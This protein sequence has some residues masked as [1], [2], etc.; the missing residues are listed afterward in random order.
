MSLFSG[1]IW[2]IFW[3]V[4]GDHALRTFPSRT[5]KPSSVFGH[6]AA[7]ESMGVGSASGGVFMLIEVDFRDISRIPG[8][9]NLGVK[10]VRS[11]QKLGPQKRK[12]D[13][14]RGNFAATRQLLLEGPLRDNYPHPK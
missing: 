13:S 2:R 12:R 9:Q 4:W 11:A 8:R 7:V 5:L 3:G 10:R 14:P 1:G 6:F